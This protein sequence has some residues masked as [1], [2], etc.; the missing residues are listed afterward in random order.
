M[1]HSRQRRVGLRSHDLTFACRHPR[2]PCEDPARSYRGGRFLRQSA[3]GA[4]GGAAAIWTSGGGVGVNWPIRAISSFRSSTSIGSLA[5]DVAV[6]RRPH[7]PNRICVFITPP[8]SKLPS[9]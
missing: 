4:G 1:A 2:Q 9:D 3:C 6:E 8:P 7:I 5:D